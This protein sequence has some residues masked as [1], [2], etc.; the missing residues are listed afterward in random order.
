M[1]EGPAII[2]DDVSK[3]FKIYKSR[4]G[5]LKER[6]TK[7]ARARYDEF[8][9]L[10]DVSLE[11]PHGTVYGLV[12]HNGSGKSSLLRLMAGIHRPTSGRIT[13]H[14]RI[15][16]LL[17]LGAG[18]HP[19]LTGRENIYLNA[20]ILGFRRR[21]TDKILDEIIDFSGIEQFI[22]T[23]V[24]HYSSGMYV[25]LGFSVAVHVDPQILLIDEV[26][27]VGDEEFQRKCFEH[28]YRLRNRGVTIVVVTHSLGLVRS[29]CHQAAWLDHGQLMVEGS[30]DD[31][32]HEYLS[33]VNQEE[34]DRL[35]A[36]ATAEAARA[37]ERRVSGEPTL[38]EE[39]R[40][41]H[42]S[43]VEFLDRDGQHTPVALTRE[44]LTVRVHYRAD[45][46]IELPLFSFAIENENGV[47]I[48]TP[49]MRP[50]E[51]ASS[52]LEGNGHIDYH[53]D[54]LPLAPGEYVLSF[55]VHDAAGMVRF[56]Y[57]ERMAKLR[58]QPSSGNV[59]G[60]V[61]LLGSWDAPVGSQRKPS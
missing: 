16:A 59:P 19:D 15:S 42:I 56:D 53:V 20:A 61:D 25:R 52:T 6:A 38:D 33:K 36:E 43:E 46:P 24:K 7:F 45:S 18:F 10:K 11:V 17:E 54:D 37:A 35:D 14:G 58:V 57:H 41:V 22:D 5:S 29:M 34:A 51:Q 47:H 60:L 39:L 2:V 44:P 12:G 3:R 8:W 27:A 4:P 23:P 40:P 1:S 28:L 13:T 32:V 9:A 49:R 50:G 21:D 31:V 30:A 55:A 26:I 48:A